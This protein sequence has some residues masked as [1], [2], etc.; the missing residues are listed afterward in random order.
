MFFCYYVNPIMTDV[1]FL[2]FEFINV[3]HPFIDNMGDDIQLDLILCHVACVPIIW[4]LIS[5]FV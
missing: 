4:G 3:S 2:P 5:G 1:V